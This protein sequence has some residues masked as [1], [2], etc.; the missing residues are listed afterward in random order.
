MA[1]LGMF[2]L[3]K[4]KLRQGSNSNLQYLKEGC[5]EDRFF[6]LGHSKRTRDNGRK[7]RQGKFLLDRR[8]TCS[9]PRVARY[10]NRCLERLGNL[11]P[12]GCSEIAWTRP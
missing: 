12:W 5:R 1:V 8:K 6:L 7:L 2:I 10:W 3:Q 4:R 11:Y 9:P